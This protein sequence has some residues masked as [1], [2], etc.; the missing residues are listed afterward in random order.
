MN[1]K[2]YMIQLSKDSYDKAFKYLIEN[3]EITKN[4]G[5]DKEKSVFY[6][7]LMED[8]IEEAK[9]IYNKFTNLRDSYFNPIILNY[10]IE[11]KNP[12]KIIEF[13]KEFKNVIDFNLFNAE[14]KRSL[15]HYICIYLSG[16]INKFEKLFSFMDNLKIDYL[17]KDKLERNFLFYLFLDQNDKKKKI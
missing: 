1:N 8:Y 17:L 6:L 15:I 12:E 3:I 4:N 9:I 14:H 2:E 16:D 13:L 5:K 11:N 10:I 7:C